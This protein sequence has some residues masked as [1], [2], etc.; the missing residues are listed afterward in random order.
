MFNASS[1]Q[2]S[3]N[4]TLT[5]GINTGSQNLTN[6]IHLGGNYNASTDFLNGN[7]AEFLIINGA[8]SS[9]AYKDWRVILPV[10]GDKPALFTHLMAKQQ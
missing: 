4:G 1:G 8:V 3:V 10:N 7:I 5:S 9:A 6:G 2:I